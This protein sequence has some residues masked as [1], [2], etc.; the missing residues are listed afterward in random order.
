MKFAA[1]DQKRRHHVDLMPVIAEPLRV[2]SATPPEREVVADHPAPKVHHRCEP[3]DEF[4]RRQRR[5]LAIETQHDGVLDAGSLDERELFL[6][7]RD[8]LRAVRGIQD[9]ARVRFEGD[10][11]RLRLIHLGGG[12][13]MA[14]HVDVA[15]V[16]AV[17]AADS[18]CHWPNGARGKSEMDLQSYDLS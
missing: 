14:E 5:Q 7:R 17:E 1:V 8:G 9:A 15:E 3:V 13:N 2:A 16:H 11:C 4:L 12:D 6:K 10:Q 18:Q